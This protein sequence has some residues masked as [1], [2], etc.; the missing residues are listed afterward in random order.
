MPI[1]AFYFCCLTRVLT[2]FW[3]LLWALF[4][5]RKIVFIKSMVEVKFHNLHFLLLEITYQTTVQKY[6]F[7]KYVFWKW[8]KVCS[9]K[10]KK[11]WWANAGTDSWNCWD[12][13]TSQRVCL[14][15]LLRILEN[16]LTST[17]HLSIS[18]FLLYLYLLQIDMLKAVWNL[19]MLPDSSL[20]VIYHYLHA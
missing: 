5:W 9:K 12:I 19:K 10:S 6:W 4:E 14:I 11:Y 15:I 20:N 2:W 3:W 8:M 13:N 18:R 17:S 16:F 1:A 7:L